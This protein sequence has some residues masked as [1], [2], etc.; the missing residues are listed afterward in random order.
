MRV[1]D[2][3]RERNRLMGRLCEKGGKR[4]EMPCHHRLEDYLT[5]YINATAALAR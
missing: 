3:F 5:A 2:A 4:Q 1:E